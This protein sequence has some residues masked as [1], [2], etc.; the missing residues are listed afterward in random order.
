M[1]LSLNYFLEANLALCIFLVVFTLILRNETS[2]SLK[3]AMLLT[4]I[5]ASLLFPAVHISGAPLHFPTFSEVF[6]VKMLPEM[7]V[8]GSSEIETSWVPPIS[9][10]QFV[11]TIYLAGAG[12]MLIIFLYRMSRLL[13]FIFRSEKKR[14]GKLFVVE[15]TNQSAPFSFFNFIFIGQANELTDREKELI[16]AHES[17]HAKYFHTI[18]ILVVE[19][20]RIIFWFNPAIKFYKDIFI[21]LHEFEADARSVKNEELGAYCNLLARVA[22]LSA[23][24]RIA[25]HFSN[26]L[27]LKRI[28]MMR[29][30]KSNMRPWKVAA[31]ALMVPA[32]FVLLSCQDQLVNE[33]TDIAKSSTVAMDVPEEVQKKYD[34]MKNAHPELKLLLMEIPDSEEGYSKLEKIQK[35]IEGKGKIHSV[36]LITPTVKDSE[37]LRHFMIIEYNESVSVIA[38][39]S[40]QDNVYTVVEESATPS[41][42][43]QDFYGFLA[44]NISY[45]KEAR[46]NGVQGKVFVSFIVE[47]D[48]SLSDLQISKGV[49]DALDAEA[50]RVVK[51]SPK[52]NPAKHKGAIVRQRMVLPINF[53]ID[54]PKD[55]K[56]GLFSTPINPLEFLHPDNQ[57]KC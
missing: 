21:Q 10:L 16:M 18:D 8:V 30:I 53:M 38:E 54:Q 37:P 40:Q 33:V 6:S 4:G 12:L 29:T 22:L 26:S 48:G 44:Q 14:V 49:S 20:V 15:S 47:T 34:E 24:I 52:W 32:F 9:L 46:G 19:M 36:N 23:D 11:Y 57:D 7:V 3:R 43:I 50:I 55:K 45:P 2:F 5:A 25:N 39:R 41:G 27:T 31:I 56:V 51:L 13:I 42:G 1:N 35:D 17:V 28:Q